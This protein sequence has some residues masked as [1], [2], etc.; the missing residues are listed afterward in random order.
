MVIAD[1]TAYSNYM[2]ITKSLHRDWDL[3]IVKR[4]A[5]AACV[6]GYYGRKVMYSSQPYVGFNKVITNFPT[7]TKALY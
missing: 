5:C 4:I 3:Y 6:T 1:D 7:Q 2:R